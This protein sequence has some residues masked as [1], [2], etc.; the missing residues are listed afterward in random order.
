MS[1][2]WLRCSHGSSKRKT[3]QHTTEAWRGGWGEARSQLF[4]TRAHGARAQPRAP[5]ALSGIGLPGGSDLPT[6]R[7]VSPAPSAMA[8]LAATSALAVSSA[9][10][11]FHEVAAAGKGVPTSM[12]G[13]GDSGVGERHPGNS[14]G[15]SSG[16]QLLLPP[17]VTHGCSSASMVEV[18]VGGD[19]LR[20]PHVIG[21]FIQ[22]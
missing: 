5:H 11:G 10:V 6:I 3:K 18:G 15:S 22:H 9:G 17:P 8:Q 2:P 4:S 20:P 7:E 12:R 19:T 16:D 1:M 13:G 14:G 21:Q